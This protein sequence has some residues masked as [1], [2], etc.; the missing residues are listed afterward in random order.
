MVATDEGELGF[1]ASESQ[2]MMWFL[3]RIA[4]GDPSYNV[5]LPVRI[6]GPVDA[7]SLDLAVRALVG[8]HPVLTSRFEHRDGELYCAPA[9]DSPAGL[10]VFS[11]SAG[12]GHHEAGLRAF[13]RAPFDLA[14][15]PLFRA[16]LFRLGGEEGILALCAHHAAADVKSFE[17]MLDEL[18]DLYSLA[19]RG[20]P[21]ASARAFGGR[22]FAAFTAE[23]RDYLG[24][25]A[26]RRDKGFWSGALA[27]DIQPLSFGCAQEAAEPFSS[28]PFRLEDGTRKRMHELGGLVDS[29]PWCLFL[30]AWSVAVAEYTGADRFA[31]GMPTSLRGNSYTSTVG[32]FV[33]PLAIA[34]RV[35]RE[36]R[37]LDLVHRALVSVSKA[38][39]HKQLPFNRVVGLVPGARFGTANPV[40]QTLVNFLGPASAGRYTDLHV[41]DGD[42]AGLT[43]AN[44]Y[45]RPAFVPQQEGQVGLALEIVQSG[46]GIRGYVRG[47]AFGTSSQ[48]ADALQSRF[49]EV[50]DRILRAPRDVVADHGAR[51]SG[52]ASPHGLGDRRTLVTLLDAVAEAHGDR[53]AVSD[54]VG[55]MTFAGLRDR[56]VAI[57]DLLARRGVESG[58]RV[59]LLLPPSAEMI[60][61]MLGVMRAGGSYV[62]MEREQPQQRLRDLAETCSVVNI[63]CDAALPSV[64]ADGRRA[65]DL[66][67]A[68]PSASAFDRSRP[69]GFAYT[70]FTS[71]STGRPKGIDVRHS[72]VVALLDAMREVVETGAS[73]V[74][75]WFHAASFDLSVWEIWGALLSSA[76]LVVTPSGHRRNPAK[77]LALLDEQR[78]TVLQLTPSALGLLRVA[79]SDQPTPV[80]KL[81][82]LVSCGEALPADTAAHFLTWTQDMWNMY[83]PAE[84]TVYATHHRIAGL[85]RGAGLVPIGRPLRGYR[86]YLLDESLK[87]VPEGAEGEIFIAGSGVAAGY[88]NAPE[89]T[90]E[91]FLLDPFTDDGS[92]MYRTGDYAVV[93]NGILEYLGRRDQQVKVHGYRVDLLEVEGAARRLA[94]VRDA[95]VLCRRRAGQAEIVA[96]IVFRNAQAVDASTAELERVLREALPSHMVPSSYVK[97]PEM[98]LNAHH[99]VD[100]AALARMLNDRRPEPRPGDPSGFE[101]LI[102]GFW[103]A[104]LGK[105]GLSMDRSFFDAG[106]DSFA[107]VRVFGMMEESGL[108]PGIRLMDLFKYPTAAKLAAFAAG[109]STDPLP[110]ARVVRHRRR[111]S[112]GAS[113]VATNGR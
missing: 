101:G 3:D 66:S 90:E 71:G 19:L 113:G 31:I 14:R 97:I 95:A 37:Y 61:A 92:R 58:E 100:R 70:L 54:G 104:A 42:R 93:R 12:L 74:W 63:V 108:F 77:L 80:R 110:G 10:E 68:L 65:V 7:V 15:G 88:A 26:C 84:T 44:V 107:L 79:T 60:A 20:V 64:L 47:S 34:C 89:S 16:A 9:V 17:V 81:R 103:E 4:P 1:R 85:Q 49:L 99:K 69:D 96:F 106:G 111:P 28:R 13:L 25:D 24:S 87:G 52:E 112:G 23:E 78:V 105:R 29:N 35:D 67:E 6:I 83:G 75:C 82:H 41:N 11:Y 98:P 94:P 22:S 33:N 72:N 39:S 21:P 62:P 102:L 109:R 32:N 46:S 53:V 73:D 51:R 2:R 48:D 30:A 8:R 5:A 40:F 76:R 43:W 55:E 86:V 18:G 50:L 36:D 27:S 38:A 45:M 91:R 57:A 56:S 59:G